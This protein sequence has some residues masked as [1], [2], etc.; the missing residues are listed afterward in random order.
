MARATACS[1]SDCPR[2]L[3]HRAVPLLPSRADGRRADR[4]HPACRRRPDHQAD[5]PCLPDTRRHH[6]P[7][8]YPRQAPGQGQRHPVQH[9]GSRAV[10]AAASRGPARALPHFHRRLRRRPGRPDRRG[11]QAGPPHPPSAARRHR[12]NRP[13][14]PD[15]AHRGPPDR[16]HRPRRRAHP[17]GGSGPLP[18]EHV[19]DRRGRCPGDQRTD[20]RPGRPV[21][22]P[23]CD[24]RPA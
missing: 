7:P 17:D 10:P 19:D 18:L 4:A 13:A 14:R 15:A 2:R 11:D 5:R 6:D 20:R 21:P 3:T 16:A 8:H 1:S 24:R 22:A 12:G 23:G 9:A